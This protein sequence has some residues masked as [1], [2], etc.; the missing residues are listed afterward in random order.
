M[1][2][3]AKIALIL[4]LC[5][6]VLI[7]LVVVVIAVFVVNTVTAPA[8]AANTYIKALNAGDISTAW[9]YLTTRTQNQETR[10]G[11]ESKVAQLKGSVSNWDTSVVS[12]QNGEAKVI[13]NVTGT[14]G[15]HHGWDIVLKKQGGKWK[16]DQISRG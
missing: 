9:S 1:S 13:I 3:G 16:V 10:Q 7:I 11:F 8:D 15:S 5:A 4:S 12:I 6:I 2:R 14:D